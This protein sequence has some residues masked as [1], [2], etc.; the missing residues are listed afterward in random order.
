MNVN[1]LLSRLHLPVE[2][3][4]PGFEGATT[5][6]NSEPI[7][8]AT[9]EGKVVAVD[10]WTYTCINWLRTL[11]H[12]RAWAD[13]YAEHG[14]VVIGVHT[15]EFEVEHDIENVRR[16]VREM[17]VRYPVA[18]DNDYAVWDAFANRYW[19][20][21]YV[22]DADAH[23]RHHNFGEGGY[24]KSERAIRQLLSDA[25]AND[26]PDAPVAIDPRGIEVAADWHDLRSG[27]TYV[28]VA[29]S[30]GFVSPGLPAV[31]EPRAYTA[32]PRLRLNEWALVGN[33]TLEREDAVCNEAGG[34]INYCFHAR[35]LHL[36]LAPP[37]AGGSARFRVRLDGTAPGDA[38]GLDVDV[39]GNGVVTEPR[40][41]QLIRQTAPIADRQFEIEFL[42]PG[43]AALCFTFG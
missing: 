11:P 26:L 28:G 4:M 6:L 12:L 19:P 8:S 32:P 34:R 7:E 40:L 38:H 39:A 42:D 36:I 20:A 1:D 18:I 30:E 23:L 15:P 41:H 9:L 25:G 24:D 5:W 37:V 29:R 2:N 21:L 16:A 27:E 13:T 43:A 31:D 14:L 33:W 3:R 35:D 17:D 10:F 22:A